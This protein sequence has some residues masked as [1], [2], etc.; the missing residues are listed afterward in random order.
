[1]IDQGLDGDVVYVTSKNASF[2]GPAN[3][4]YSAAKADQAHQVRL[5]AVELGDQ[6]IRV[7]GVA[8]DGVVQGSGIFAGGWGAERAAVYGVKEEDLGAF[9]AQRTLL[10]REVIPYDVAKA[11]SALASGD[12][13]RTTGTVVPVDSGVAGAFLR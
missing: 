4:A 11:I 5:L 8:P 1:M 7:N 6:G 2:A 10:K 9:Y 13:S 3:I 12:L